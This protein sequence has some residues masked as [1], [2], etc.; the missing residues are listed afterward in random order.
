MG[1]KEGLQPRGISPLKPRNHPPALVEKGC[2]QR[3]RGVLVF[4]WC[5]ISL[6]L[7]FSSFLFLS[8]FL[9][10]TLIKGE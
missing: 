2:S 10:W 7:G 3:N 5:R 4:S 1:A 9:Q 8:P 6:K